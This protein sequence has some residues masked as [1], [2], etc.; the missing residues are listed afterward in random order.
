MEILI[1][2]YGPDAPFLDYCLK[3]IQKFA[4]GFAGVTVLAPY[5]DAALIGPLCDK[6]GA[7]MKNDYRSKPPLGFLDHMVAKCFAD[8]WCPDAEFILHVD[9]DCVFTEPVT[10]EDYFVDGKPVLLIEPFSKIGPGNWKPVTDSVMKIDSKYE[11]MRRHPA[12]HYRDVYPALQ[13]HVEAAQQMGFRDYVLTRK[14][15]FPW[16]FSEFV[17]L[18]QIALSPER[19][20]RYHFI[21]LSQESAPK[22]KL[23]QFWSKWGL[24]G[25]ITD[26]GPFLGRTPRAV[27]ADWGL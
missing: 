5:S 18:G 15:D 23:H 2:T 26:Q 10:P 24:D 17:A 20:D 6:Y 14:S 1:V 7:H 9:S 16:G 19:R 3:S 11:T 13:R 4:T 21:D 8:E 12:V 25:R 22:H 27:M